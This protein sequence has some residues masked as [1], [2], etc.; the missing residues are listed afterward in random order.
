MN[1]VPLMLAMNNYNSVQHNNRR[2]KSENSNTY[3]TSVEKNKQEVKEEIKFEPVKFIETISSNE[4]FQKFVEVL[5]SKIEDLKLETYNK[6]GK[7]LLKTGL[8][9]EEKKLTFEEDINQLS[10]MN[11]QISKNDCSLLRIYSK[12]DRILFFETDEYGSIINTENNL[13]ISKIIINDEHYYEKRLESL[14]P[15][16]VENRYFELKNKVDKYYKKIKFFKSLSKKEKY[17]DL[18]KDFDKVNTEYSE[19]LSRKADLKNYNELSMEQKNAM[20]KYFEDLDELIVLSDIVKKTIDDYYEEIQSTDYYYKALEY[21]I[22]NNEYKEDIMETVEF[23]NDTSLLL[24]EDEYFKNDILYFFDLIKNEDYYGFFRPTLVSYFPGREDY[25][26]FELFLVNGDYIKNRNRLKR[27]VFYKDTA[28]E[29]QEY[30]ES[31][32]DSKNI[33]PVKTIDTRKTN[34]EQK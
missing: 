7:K 8:Q 17:I 24:L 22:K 25:K 6:Y 34:K 14:N 21:F 1:M 29:E 3:E 12:E 27:I 5:L 15:I 4:K 19:V 18:L 26:V 13:N 28:V 32:V 9:Y 23:V 16:D 33:V 10:K 11:L 20:K 31:L 30:S 2:R